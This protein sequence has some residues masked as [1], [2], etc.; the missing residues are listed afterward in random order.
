[1]TNNLDN[2]L[3]HSLVNSQMKEIKKTQFFLTNNFFDCRD[4]KI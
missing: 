2:I 3:Q 4:K 1:M